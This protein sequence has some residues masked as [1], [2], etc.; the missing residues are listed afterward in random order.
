M[1][2]FSAVTA[3]AAV[4]ELQPTAL[5]A[6]LVSEPAAVFLLDVRTTPEFNGGHLVGT[7][8]V[9]MNDVPK[10]VA[11]IPKNRKVVVMC[12]TGARSSA[13]ARY[14]DQAGYPWVANLTGGVMSWM[15]QG[16]PVAR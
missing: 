3:Q 9:P 1:F 2:S 12:A 7:T 5:K 13:V 16:L 14:L 11:E 10:R 6:L 8:L 15:R 4:H